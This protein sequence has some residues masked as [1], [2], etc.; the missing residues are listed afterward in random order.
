MST[1]SNLRLFIDWLVFGYTCQTR[2]A[3]FTAGLRFGMDT[4]R[5]RTAYALWDF[6]RRLPLW[7]NRARYWLADQ[8]ARASLALRGGRL[9][10]FGWFDAQ[11]GNAAARQV[12]D[13][14]MDLLLLTD[15]SDATSR[16]RYLELSRK[17]HELG[18]LKG[19]LSYTDLS[20]PP[21]ETPAISRP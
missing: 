21:R 5:G 11:F 7:P 20:A 19:A 15:F 3:T 10:R 4:L 12:E 13:I 17:V 2:Y 9:Y 6:W 18:A 14:E 16:E 8:L 1:D